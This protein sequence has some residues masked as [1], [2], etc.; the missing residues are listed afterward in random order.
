MRAGISDPCVECGQY[1]MRREKGKRPDGHI[2]CPKCREA[3]KREQTRDRVKAYRKRKTTPASR[4]RRGGSISE[5][6]LTIPR[7]TK[8]R[9]SAKS[10]SRVAEGREGRGNPPLASRTLPPLETLAEHNAKLYTQVLRELRAIAELQ[11]KTPDPVI[12]GGN[13]GKK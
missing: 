3:A 7:P 1:W 12:H 11:T 4:S 5:G 2:R 10:I 9:K 13:H 6:D 8:S